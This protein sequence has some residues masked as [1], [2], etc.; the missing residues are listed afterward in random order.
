MPSEYLFK[1]GF[2]GY[3]IETLFET[4]N[5]LVLVCFVGGGDRSHPMVLLGLCSESILELLD[6]SI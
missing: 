1:V 3:R 6:D 5:E 4:V 2:Y